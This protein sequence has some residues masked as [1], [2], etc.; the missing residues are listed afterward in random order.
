MFDVF[1]K[2][3]VAVKEYPKVPPDMLG[4]EGGGASKWSK[5]IAS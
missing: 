2:S 1:T 3:E 5:A 4:N